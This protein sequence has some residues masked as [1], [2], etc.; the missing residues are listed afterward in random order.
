MNQDVLVCVHGFVGIFHNNVLQRPIDFAVCNVRHQRCVG[1][2][3]FGSHASV[4]F[5]PIGDIA[6]QR[7]ALVAEMASHRFGFII[8]SHK[9][10]L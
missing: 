1:E 7:D 10:G 5:K 2:A 3:E 6:K 8:G 9:S 4:F